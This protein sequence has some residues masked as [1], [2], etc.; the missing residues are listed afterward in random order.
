MK[1]L[2]AAAGTIL[3]GLKGKPLEKNANKKKKTD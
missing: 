3:S 1:V 2:K